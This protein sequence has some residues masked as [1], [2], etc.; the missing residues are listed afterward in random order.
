MMKYYWLLSLAIIGCLGCSEKEPFYLGGVQV[1]EADQK[2]WVQLVKKVGMNTIEVTAYAKQGDW[3]SDNIWYNRDEPYVLSEIRA[4]KAEGLNV[5]LILRTAVDHAFPANKFLWHG[6]IIPS[7]DSLTREWFRNYSNF[8]TMW[9][10]IAEEEHIDVLAIGSELNMMSATTP[11]DTMPGLL[12]YYNNP[13][14]QANHEKRVLKFKDQ[15]QPEDLWVRGFDNYDE[16]ET[17]IDDEIAVKTS[18]SKEVSFSGENDSLE[19][20]NHKRALL[21]EEWL[22]LIAET[23]EHYT[24]KLTYAA[25]FDNYQEVG[26]WHALDFIGINAY[27]QLREKHTDFVADSLYPEL[28]QGWESVFAEI[29]SFRNRDSLPEKPIIFTELGYIYRENCTLQPWAGFGFSVVGKEEEEALVVWPKQAINRRERAL[30]VKALYEVV[31]S[32]QQKLK[33]I[34]YWKLT[35]HDYL[36]KEEPFALLIKQEPSDSLQ[37]ALVDFV[38]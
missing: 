36:V 4:A 28:R 5:V 2:E 27:F 38:D 6:M 23:R 3:N 16:L 21:Q 26:F 12:A 17:Y 8:V 31:T 15:L 9:A 11:T 13:T 35:G 10:K 24:G 37:Q 18:W 32:Q 33:G 14:S 34:L 30:A 29:D 19:R 25:N 1:H 22:L 7:S 20:L